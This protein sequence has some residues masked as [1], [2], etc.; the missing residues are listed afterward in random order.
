MKF[1][2]I[3]QGSL[4]LVADDNPINLQLMTSMLPKFGCEVITAKDGEAALELATRKAPDLILLDIHMPIMD[5]YQVC[6]QLKQDEHTRDI[7]VIFV[8]ALHEEFNKV[9]AFELGGVDYVSKPIKIEEL[10][11]RMSTHL[12][13]ARQK[14]MLEDQAEEL[15][16]MIGREVRVLELKKEVNDLCREFGRDAPYPEADE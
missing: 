15:R 16:S 14:K 9:K 7:P 1:K 2:E 5:G 4:I 6:E 10:Q 13:I 8:S 11:A 3:I 12:K